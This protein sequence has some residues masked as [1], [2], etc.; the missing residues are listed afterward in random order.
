MSRKT[1]RKR[2]YQ[3]PHSDMSVGGFCIPSLYFVFLFYEGGG[4]REKMYKQ[5]QF[6]LQ[7]HKSF[8]SHKQLIYLSTINIHTNGIHQDIS[9]YNGYTLLSYNDQRSKGTRK[10]DSFIFDLILLN[11][12]ISIMFTTK[13][14]TISEQSLC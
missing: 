13:T 6:S 8:H 9:C 2:K 1:K 4:K 14:T 5:S 10:Y 11:N 3:W 7:N 12:R